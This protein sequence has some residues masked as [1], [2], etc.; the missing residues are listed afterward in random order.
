MHELFGT[1]SAAAGQKAALTVGTWR[2]R[3]L[4]RLNGTPSALFELATHFG[5]PDHVLSGRLSE[6]ARDGWRLRLVGEAGRAEMLALTWEP[7]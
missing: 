3:I 5:V 1:T 7:A 6:L 2:W 4:D